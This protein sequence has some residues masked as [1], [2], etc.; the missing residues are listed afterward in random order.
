M[1]NKPEILAPV[2]SFEAL[3]S[4][5][6]NGADAVYF[7]GQS[8]GAR[9][10]ATNF[11]NDEIVDIINYC[12]I[13][14]VKVYVTV[15][16]LIK[17]KEFN[18]A[19]EFVR[20]LYIN[21]V[22]AV[23][24]QDFGLIKYCKDVF[25]DL[26]IHASTQINCHSLEQALFLQKLG[27]KRIVLSRELDIDVIKDI[28]SID[29]LEIEVFIHGALCVSY[30]G[31]CFMSSFNGGRSGNRGRCAQPCRKFYSLVDFEGGLI[32]EG[33]LLSTKDL[34]TINDIQDIIDTGVSSLK[35]EGRMKRPEYVGL[36]VKSYKDAINGNLDKDTTNN[37]ALMYNREFTRGFISKVNNNDITN[38]VT[39]NHVGLKIG[40]VVSSTSNYAYIS[41]SSELN[42]QDSIRIVGDV[43]D[44]VTING[45]YS[46][47]KI[48]QSASK[49]MTV[50]IRTHKLVEVG[51]EVLKTTDNKLIN[52]INQTLKK[53][54]GIKG[55]I[56]C[57]NE[58]LYLEIN[59]GKNI[60]SV[61]SNTKV[62][63]SSNPT[64]YLRFTDQIN[65]TNDSN[66]YFE[67]LV[68]E[69]KGFFLQVSEVNELR[70]TALQMLDNLRSKPRLVRF[71]EYRP[72]NNNISKD[73]FKIY[74]KVRN[75]EQLLQA[76]KLNVKDILVE[77][78]E[79]LKHNNNIS[80]LHLLSPRIKR[81]NSIDLVDFSSYD[82][83]S[84]YS[85][86]F[87]SYSMNLFIGLGI[88]VVGLSIELNK[89]EIKD[90][91]SAYYRIHN[92]IPNTMLMAY[93][94]QEMMITKHCLINKSEG[95]S[96]KGCR[97]CYQKQYYLQDENDKYPLIDDGNC[98]LKILKT[99][100]IDLINRIDEIK[101]IGISSIL[102]DFSIEKDI[103]IIYNKYS[104]GL[105]DNL[106]EGLYEG[107]YE[108]GVI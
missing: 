10:Y 52:K 88:K 18:E 68:N 19:V 15:N 45:M 55:K 53:K 84:P 89:E 17:E 60:F 91:I 73:E 51:S 40:E 13:M 61:K 54:I 49:G 57:N 63:N 46:N 69:A 42:N 92:V 78:K 56:Y 25:L 32:D 7:G 86:I 100:P 41:L 20:F 12:H 11:T 43:V 3:Y 77:D 58:Y 37:L 93:G 9:A 38:T 1:R 21:N 30:S 83:L 6:N 33:Y 28:A 96:K 24:M 82:I 29:N 107:H 105:K 108:E 44:A 26:T 97:L 50:K 59:D 72:I 102:L 98:N 39:P 75:E 64:Y 87:N 79:L 62:I 85:N 103:N 5:I 47:D 80:S 65:K 70:R 23:I 66:Y 16:T 101:E 2:G 22:D 106:N 99:K 95:L 4:A 31:N 34:M 81:D 104:L 71:G 76:I 36:T 94:Y 67:S 14:D 74:V 27:I 35:I 48:V 8:F 90:I